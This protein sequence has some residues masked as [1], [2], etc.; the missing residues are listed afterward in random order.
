MSRLIPCVILVMCVLSPV[1]SHARKTALTPEAATSARVTPGPNASPGRGVIGAGV[2]QSWTFDVGGNPNAQGWTTV[3]RTA[4][5]A[6]FHVVNA[7]SMPGFGGHAVWCGVGASNCSAMDACGYATLPGYGNDWK[8]F[9]QTQSI[10]VD[11]NYSTQIAFN[12]SY[13][14]EPNY[15]F[16]YLEYTTGG[17]I[18]NLLGTWT[19]TGNLIVGKS[20]PAGTYTS[21]IRVRLRFYSD[22]SASDEDGGYDSS[23]GPVY[24][25]NLSIVN[26]GAFVDI[27]DFTAEALNATNTVDGHWIAF[28]PTPFGN[29]AALFNG[30]AV[31]QEDPGVFNSTYMWGFF[32][33]SPENY[34]CGGFPAQAIVPHKLTSGNGDLYI[35]NEIQSPVVALTGIGAT[36][37]V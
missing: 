33:G 30:S 20:I 4:Q 34:A 37:A 24:I 12:L 29:K 28:G 9:W 25:D 11:P 19:G 35:H 31:L 3:D 27:H 15:D 10:S 36:E 14:M 17:G 7:P 1:N 2:L 13:D 23:N 18:W 6:L 21:P 8:Q 26:N 5:P 32:N 22:G 16:L